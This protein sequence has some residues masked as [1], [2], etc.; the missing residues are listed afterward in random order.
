MS[1]Y[2]FPRVVLTSSNHTLVILISLIISP[3]CEL[4][5]SAVNIIYNMDETS[6][7]KIDILI[8]PLAVVIF[9]CIGMTFF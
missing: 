3:M 9:S 2:R 8:L 6:K 4:L 1:N 5:T 7:S